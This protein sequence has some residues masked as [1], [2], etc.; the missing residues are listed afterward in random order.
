[1]TAA[2][3]VRVIDERER[4][5]WDESVQTLPHVQAFNAFD[6]GSVRQIDGWMPIHLVAERDGEVCGAL[7]ILMRRL[8][9]TPYRIFCGP[10]GPLCRPDDHETVQAI[11]A[12]VLELA[13]TH[14]AIVIRVDP[15]IREDEGAPLQQT[16]RQL[17]YHHLEQRWTFWNN[18]RDEYRIDLEEQATADELH[19]A[20]DRDTRRCIR[21]GAKDGLTI[22]PATTEAELQ[23]FFEI[24]QSFTIDKEFMARGYEYQRQLWKAYVERGRGRLFLAK[25]Q[26]GIIGGLICIQ[27][28]RTCVAMHMGTPYQYHKLHTYY[29][30]VWES[31][32]WAKES[33]SRWYSFRGVGTTPTQEAFKRKFNPKVVPLA[34]YFDYPFRPRLYR[35]FYWGEFTL[36]PAAW[37]LL[38]KGRKLAA[39]LFRRRAQSPTAE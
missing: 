26:G 10:Q 17:G 34:G 27:F 3:T 2:V 18:P 16:L 28:G 36:L 13:R 8:P 39:G 25:Y 29:A 20:L 21:K 9:Y 30:Y 12:K 24:F 33:G 23:A 5:Y 11:H 15:N 37:P 38:V 1:M 35:L 22:E 31:I 6:W 7:L 32:K 4:D 19:D 14:R